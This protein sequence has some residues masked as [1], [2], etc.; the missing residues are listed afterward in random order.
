M[1]I[2]HVFVNKKYKYVFISIAPDWLEDC[3]N[4]NY[5]IHNTNPVLFIISMPRMGYEITFN[6]TLICTYWLESD[7]EPRCWNLHDFHVCHY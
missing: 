4:H 7:I 1:Y 5:I 3:L 6:P 2:V